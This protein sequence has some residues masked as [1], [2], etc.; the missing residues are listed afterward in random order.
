MFQP[1]SLASSR[2]SCRTLQGEETLNYDDARWHFG[3]NFPKDSPQT[4]EGTHIALLLRW[5]YLKRWIGALHLDANPADV[6]RMKLGEM[7][8][9]DFFFQWCNGK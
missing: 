5:C 7:S 4:C 2:R 9:T 3:G 6:E 1:A 8:A